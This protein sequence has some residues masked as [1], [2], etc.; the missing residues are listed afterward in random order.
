[1][2]KHNYKKLMMISLLWWGGNTALA[3]DFDAGDYTAMPAG[4]N[5]GLLYYTHSHSGNYVSQGHSTKHDT[6]LNQDVSVLRVIHFTTIG[7]FTV[8]PQ[9]LLPFGHVNGRLGG[10]DMGSTQGVGDLILA[11]TVWFYNDPA[12]QTYFGV[13][14]FLYAPT[15]RYRH[16]GSLNMGENRWKYALQAAFSTPVY[17]KLLLDIGLDATKFGDNNDYGV[18]SSRLS[19]NTL[20]Q[21]QVHLRYLI[22]PALDLRTSYTKEWGGNSSVDGV[23]QGKPA[24]NKYT[25]GAAY[26]FPSHTQLLGTWGRDAS[27]ENGFKAESVIKLRLMQMF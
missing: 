4:T 10:N 26:M 11:S 8:D 16:E 2:I 17:D 5:L 22:T 23:S 18:Q 15:G 19:Q 27:I 12:T 3:I 13:T 25:F 21:G 9:F 20:Y 7:G 14:P 1:M 24:E 6:K